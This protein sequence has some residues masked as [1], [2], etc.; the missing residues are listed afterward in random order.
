MIHK[1]LSKSKSH[2]NMGS[3]LTKNRFHER[4]SN[5]VTDEQEG[6]FITRL[7]RGSVVV[8]PWAMMSSA[9]FYELFEDVRQLLLERPITHN[10]GGE[11]L[12]TLKM[13]MAKI[14]VKEELTCGT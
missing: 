14:Q 7:H 10:T 6:N 3:I 1:E 4:F 12:Y 9:A 8:M 5:I 13:L 11:F 2:F